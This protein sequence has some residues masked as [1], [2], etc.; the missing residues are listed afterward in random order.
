M[1]DETPLNSAAAPRQ[2][3]PYMSA[4]YG[5]DFDKGNMLEWDWARERMAAAHNY[6]VATTRPDGRPHVMPVWGVW[7][8]EAFYFS[9]GRQSRKGRN[10]AANPEIVIHLESGDEV[11]IFEGRVEEF[12]NGD[13]FERF[14]EVYEAKYAGFR[15][16]FEE[17][18]GYYQL[19]PRLA[20]GW[21]ESDFV[22]SAT[23]W[24][25]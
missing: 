1:M 16:K 19:I 2:T 7:L 13:F 11:V 15:P 24:I 18:N 22:N 3:R 25:F 6:W 5:V 21:L 4:D 10:L 23:R 14:A 12:H 20:F 9:T 8:D 17:T